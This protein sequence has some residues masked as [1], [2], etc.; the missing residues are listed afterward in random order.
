MKLRARLSIPDDRILPD[1][2]ADQK[3]R[4]SET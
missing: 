1:S 2:Y 4:L 3:A